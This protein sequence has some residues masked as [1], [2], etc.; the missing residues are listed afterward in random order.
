MRSRA[1]N[2]VAAHRSQPRREQNRH[3][4]HRVWRDESRARIHS[5]KKKKNKKKKKRKKRSTQQ[6][7][8]LF[9]P[10]RRKACCDLVGSE[11]CVVHCPSAGYPGAPE[12]LR[13]RVVGFVVFN[14]HAASNERASSSS[15]LHNMPSTFNL[16]SSGSRRSA[17]SIARS[18]W[19][20][21]SSSNS[22]SNSSPAR[23][24]LLRTHS[25]VPELQL[26]SRCRARRRALSPV[27]STVTV[28]SETPHYSIAIICV[29]EAAE[30]AQLHDLR[31]P[32]SEARFEVFSRNALS[33]SMK[34]PRRYAPAGQSP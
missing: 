9:L 26:D 8:T 16:A 5:K 13:S 17:A 25:I 2:R 10:G 32:R 6:K 34:F 22:C 14:S 15:S 4:T 18:C 33:K 19:L 3:A 29:F 1:A 30:I 21:G 27:H 23:G 7:S 11:Q 20:S 24:I 31:L 28:G 12:Q